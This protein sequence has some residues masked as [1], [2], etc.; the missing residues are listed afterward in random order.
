LAHRQNNDA[1]AACESAYKAALAYLDHDN[2]TQANRMA[3]LMRSINPQSGLIE[4]LRKAIAK[5]SR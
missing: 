1:A 3:A 5:Q 2:F 4:K